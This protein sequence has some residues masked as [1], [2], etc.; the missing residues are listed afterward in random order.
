MTPSSNGA[1]LEFVEKKVATELKIQGKSEKTTKTYVFY[2]KALLSYAK[3]PSGE[4]TTDDIKEYLAYLMS[5][6]KND[7]SSVALA[8]SALAFFYDQTLK[9]NLLIGIKTP[10]KQRKIPDILTKEEVND[11]VEK[12]PEQRTRLM[13]EFMYAS[14]LRV[15][16]CANLKWEDI[17]KGQKIGRLKKGKGG[18]DRLFILSEKLL[19]DLE[20][21]RQESKGP[22]I[23]GDDIPLSSRTVQRDVKEA[24]KAAGITKDVHPHLL[25]HSFATHLLEGGT[26]I[27]MIQELLAHTNLQ[28]TQFYTHI[29][30]TM[31]RKVKSPLDTLKNEKNDEKGQMRLGTFSSTPSEKEESEKL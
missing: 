18:K 24:A 21:Y 12:T 13:V 4:I 29:S 3:K 11:L 8:R 6:R 31:L 2:N 27:R 15:S 16:E 9:K 28:T 10:K 7:S 20:S 30:T 22:Y 14:G 26:D 25:R 1:D 19:K 5:E 17:P 23:F